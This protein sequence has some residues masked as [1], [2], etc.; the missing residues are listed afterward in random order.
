MTKQGMKTLRPV[1]TLERRRFYLWF[2]EISYQ[3]VANKMT[4]KARGNRGPKSGQTAFE[5][6]LRTEEGKPKMKI[7]HEG[8]VII[9]G[10][11]NLLIRLSRCCKA[12]PGDDIVGYI[13][14]VWNPLSIEKTVQMFNFLSGTKPS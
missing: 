13:T 12:V 11:D 1:S 10:V 14:K 3:T 2:G 4:D 8:G 9:E 7:R 6:R 5:K